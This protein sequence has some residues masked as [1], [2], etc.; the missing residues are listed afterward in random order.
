M[1]E[2]VKSQLLEWAGEYNDPA[3]FQEDPIIFP[4]EFLRRGACL[5]D[6]EIAGLLA[7][8]LAWGRRSMIVR[9][10]TRLFDEMN[11]AP[12]DYVMSGDYRDDGTS[13]HRTV[14]WS[15][16][17][18][19][20]R[21]LKDIYSRTQSI[22]SFSVPQIRTQVFGQ[23]DDPKAACKKINMFRRWMVRDDGI[24]DLGVWKH[25]S[26]AE[27]VIPLDV[28]VYDQATAL[29]LTARRSKDIVTA[30]EI[31]DQFRQI[32]PEDPLLGDFAL[33]GAGVT[34]KDA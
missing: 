31:T 24:V 12:F 34:K 20:C 22:E 2:E 27:L 5:Q 7:A 9:D 21:R 17:A 19:I 10:C 4:R 18:A 14:K 8:H 25:S 3:Y 16:M 6:I 11:W 28:H 23:K 26:K 30:L 15:E 32:W 13:L 33:F 29:G 1:R